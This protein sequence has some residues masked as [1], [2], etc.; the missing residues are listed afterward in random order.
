MSVTYIFKS[1]EDLASHFEE[2]ARQAEK[3]RLLSNPREGKLLARE[4]YAFRACADT[5]RKTVLDEKGKLN[6][7]I[8]GDKA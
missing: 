5:V 8:H 3:R 6:D 7:P 4:A 2:Q 1:L